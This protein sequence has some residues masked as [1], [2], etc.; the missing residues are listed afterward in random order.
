MPDIILLIV[1]QASR[2]RSWKIT[3]TTEFNNIII[4]IQ[5]EKTERPPVIKPKTLEIEQDLT[6]KTNIPIIT[7]AHE[8][9]HQHKLKLKY[10]HRLKF[11]LQ[12]KFKFRTDKS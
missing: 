10:K 6:F 12:Y 11:K 9:E 2:V 1:Q 8:P 4:T 5:A 3:N 7:P